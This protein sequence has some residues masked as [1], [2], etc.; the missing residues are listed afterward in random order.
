MSPPLAV[1]QTLP[2][3]ET[4]LAGFAW[5]VAAVLAGFLILARLS[6]G[7]VDGDG[8]DGASSDHREDATP[9]RP[10]PA[11]RSG[12]DGRDP[13]ATGRNAAGEPDDGDAQGSSPVAHPLAPD[14]A[15]EPNGDA[16]RPGTVED[17]RARE[18]L[19]PAV[20]HDA[21]EDPAMSPGLLLLNVALTQGLFGAILAGGAWYFGVPLDVLGVSGDPLSTGLPAVAVG[22]GFGLVLWVGNELASGLAA[23]SGADYDEGLRELLAPEGVR[24]WGLL[25]GATLPTIAVVEEFIFRA[26]VVG[27]VTP[28][29]D[30]SPWLLAVVS[31]AAFA[32]GHGAQGRVGVLVTGGLGF[33]LAAGFVLTES[34]LMVVVAH[35]LVNALEFLVHEGLGLPDPVWS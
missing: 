21:R 15:L 20:A 26:A 16:D 18:P 29:L 12:F 34:L 32:L 14:G 5:L 7:V 31:S 27:A 2:A 10:R 30:A 22:V 19:E 8:D 9:E 33:A 3:P 4:D 13:V 11:G 1:A 35:Y 28:A 23:A 25:L 24:G 6:Q 17:D